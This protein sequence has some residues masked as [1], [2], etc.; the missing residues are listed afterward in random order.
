MG[1][2]ENSAQMREGTSGRRRLIVDA[3]MS[4]PKIAVRPSAVTMVMA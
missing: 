4:T 2:S 3:S 1:S